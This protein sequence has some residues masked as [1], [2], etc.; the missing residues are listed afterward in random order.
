MPIYHNSLQA[1]I[2]YKNKVKNSKIGL[3]IINKLQNKKLHAFGQ[4]IE[5]S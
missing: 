1:I 4:V 5:S 3:L 2:T